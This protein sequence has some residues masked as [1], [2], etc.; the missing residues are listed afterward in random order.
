MSGVASSGVRSRR[1]SELRHNHIL[2][3]LR[4]RNHMGMVERSG[5][6]GR[7]GQSPN[8]RW[9]DEL[10]ELHVLAHH[11]DASA[12]AAAGRWCATDI[13]ARQT[14]DAVEHVCDLVRDHSRP[15]TEHSKSGGDAPDDEHR[16]SSHTP[17]R[18]R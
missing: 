1:Q 12:T 15:A 3:S 2:Y 11:G 4:K 13:A 10:V 6:V 7:L 14:W 5:E 9:R 18:Q 16:R 8:E 17:A